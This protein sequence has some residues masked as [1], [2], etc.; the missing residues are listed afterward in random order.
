MATVVLYPT[1]LDNTLNSVFEWRWRTSSGDGRSTASFTLFYDCV[2][3]ARRHLHT[4]DFNETVAAAHEAL[5]ERQ[6]GRAGLRTVPLPA[7][8][9]V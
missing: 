7:P 5:A 4:V 8:L 2:T 9:K 3:D 6:M 1:F